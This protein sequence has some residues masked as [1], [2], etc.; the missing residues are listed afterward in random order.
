MRDVVG[1]TA[2]SGNFR[3]REAREIVRDPA[4]NRFAF[5]MSRESEGRGRVLDDVSSMRRTR[6]ERKPRRGEGLPRE[7]KTRE[8][9]VF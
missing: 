9:E 8:F 2:A 6:W 7:R 5:V 4:S 3:A 1:E